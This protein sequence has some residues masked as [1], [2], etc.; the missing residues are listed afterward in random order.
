[1]QSYLAEILQNKPPEEQADSAERLA[2]E[3]AQDSEEANDKLDEVL[4]SIGLN[5]GTV[6]DDA[7]ADKAKELA[8]EYVRGEREAVTLVNELLTGAGI[9][10]D[11]F[12]TRVLGDRI[13]EIERID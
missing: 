7:R 3:C 4:S 13:D 1:F 10:M 11:N 12:M 9:S 2:A 8:Q 5:V 6:L